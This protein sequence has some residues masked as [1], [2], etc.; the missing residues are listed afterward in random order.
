MPLHP[1]THLKD[2][3]VVVGAS[4]DKVVVVVLSVSASRLLTR[5]CDTR[6]CFVLRAFFNAA[7]AFFMVCGSDD[8]PGDEEGTAFECYSGALKFLEETWLYSRSMVT[9]MLKNTTS[10]VQAKQELCMTSDNSASAVLMH[11]QAPNGLTI[12]R[13]NTS[14][15]EVSNKATANKETHTSTNE[16]S[17]KAT[18]NKETHTSELSEFETLANRLV[19]LNTRLT[20][21]G[22]ARALTDNGAARALTNDS[23]ACSL[24]FHS[25]KAHEAIKEICMTID[26]S[27]SIDNDFSATLYSVRDIDCD[28]PV[29]LIQQKKEQKKTT[30]TNMMKK[31]KMMKMTKKTKKRVNIKKDKGKD[32][33]EVVSGGTC[34]AGPPC[35][36]FGACSIASWR[37]PVPCKSCQVRMCR[38]CLDSHQCIEIEQG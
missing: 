10:G 35:E 19:P 27:S 33:K 3:N 11:V 30:T 14:T 9:S 38:A 17:N 28:S 32:W 6:V 24:Q 12:Q 8:D 7:M 2:R 37:V 26:E 13:E 5:C 21:D 15:N 29:E 36:L 34:V 18:A 25:V 22:A 4:T 31:T 1:P 23:D 20:D 16:V